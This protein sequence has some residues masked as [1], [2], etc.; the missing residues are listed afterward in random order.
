MFDLPYSS[1]AKRLIEEFDGIQIKYGLSLGKNLFRVVKKELISAVIFRVLEK[2]M[3]V[4]L[5]FLMAFF[6]S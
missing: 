3:G 5:P 4:V 1:R 6:I 2:V